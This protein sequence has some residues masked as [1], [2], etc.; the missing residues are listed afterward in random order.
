[1]IKIGYSQMMA[2]RL[3]NDIMIGEEND[4]CRRK[5]EAWTC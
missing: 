4:K 1:M 3:D 2:E 5:D